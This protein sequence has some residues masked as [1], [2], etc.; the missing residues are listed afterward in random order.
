MYLPFAFTK[1][2]TGYVEVKWDSLEVPFN[3]CLLRTQV[4][5]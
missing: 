1:P 3:T 4:S 5:D 2:T